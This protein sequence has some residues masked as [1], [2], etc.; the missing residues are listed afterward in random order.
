M[1]LRSPEEHFQTGYMTKFLRILS[2]RYLPVPFIITACVA[3]A[4]HCNRIFV[5]SSTTGIMLL[6]LRDSVISVFRNGPAIA[7]S[8]FDNFL[9][10][11]RSAPVDASEANI[12]IVWHDFMLV[13]GSVLLLFAML[14]GSQEAHWIVSV[15][16]CF[17][18]ALGA[19][20]WWRRLKVLAKKSWAM[21]VGKMLLTSMAGALLCIATCI[22]RR[23][24]IGETGESPDAFITFV[25]LAS[26]LIVGPLAVYVIC[27]LATIW[28][29]LEAF[30][31]LSVLAF[32]E[33]V[34]RMIDQF[35]AFIAI[36]K[37]VSNDTPKQ[38]SAFEMS[39]GRYLSMISLGAALIIGVASLEPL[40]EPIVQ[41]A[42][43]K[44]L[45]LMEYAPRQICHQGEKIPAVK[46]D[47]DH[48]SVAIPVGDDVQFQTRTCEKNR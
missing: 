17:F 23:F 11:A 30:A 9:I 25:G 14:G 13:F 4:L 40:G 10:A 12:D 19:R 8:S 26:S 43:K 1:D 45:Y 7:K 21:A 3:A 35:N 6:A 44:L 37:G 48:F 31:V 32:R 39:L 34:K 41:K 20:E 18:I 27:V 16:T 47:E 2:S 15:A 28:T 22:T 38:R 24:V 29:C 46:L 42:G 33:M 5:I 36:A